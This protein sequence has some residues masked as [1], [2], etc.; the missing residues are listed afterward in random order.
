M[1]QSKERNLRIS[2][3]KEN[4]LNC[5]IMEMIKFLDNC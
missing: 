2:E 4:F 3:M 1:D 5:F